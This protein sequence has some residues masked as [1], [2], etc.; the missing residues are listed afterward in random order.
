[1]AQERIDVTE[2]APTLLVFA[3]STGNVVASVGPDGVLLIGK[4]SAAS[5]PLINII[6]KQRTK[7]SVRY[8][9]IYPESSLA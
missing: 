8:V 7:S 5:T 4:P 3:T 1:M 9:V 2:I 6:L